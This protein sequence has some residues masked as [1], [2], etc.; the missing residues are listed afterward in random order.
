MIGKQVYL[1]FLFLISLQ[2]YG[3]TTD[4][5][6]S[7][8]AQNLNGTAISQVDIYEDFQ[9]LVTVLNSGNSVE[10]TTLSI[11]FDADLSINS[12]NS[13][14]N[15]S[16]ASD[17][18]NISITDNILT[19]SIAN[20]PNN[21]SVEL[22]ILVTAPTSIGGITANGTVNPPD[23][24]QDTN[25]SNNQ[26]IIS[27]DVLDV[28]IDFSITHTQIQPT[29]GTAIAAWGDSVTYQFTITN[30]SAIDFPLS[31]I[32]G[33]LSLSSPYDNGQ[34]LVQFIA[35]ECI[36][37]TNGT[38]CP[39][40]TNFTGNSTSI[41][42]SSTIFLFG[43]PVEITAGGSI[44]F[45]M[46]YQYT[47]FTC[48][49]DPMPITVDSQISVAYNTSSLTTIDSNSVT[50]DLL[51]AELCQE[52]DICIETVQTNPDISEVIDYEQ[53]ITFETTI[54]NNGPS[55]AP[56]RFFFQNL[57]TLT[58][59][60]SA[61][62]CLATTGAVSC[63]DFSLSNNGQI[64]VS[65]DFILEPNTTITIETVLSY[66]EPECG[67]NHNEVVA[68]IRSATNILDNQIIDTNPDNNYFTN[69]VVLP[70][71]EPC[72]A[73]DLQVS[74]TQTNPELPIGISED[75]TAP[76][77]LVTYDVTVTNVG[78][79]DAIIILDDFMSLPNDSNASLSAVLL[80]VECIE[81]TGTATCFNIQ[82]ANIGVPV[83]GIIENG[84][85]DIFWQ[86]T[87]EDNWELPANSSVS[88]NLTI[89]WTPECSTDPMIGLNAVEVSYA[90]D[91][92][93]STPQNNTASLRTYFAPCIDLVVQTYPEFSQVNTNQTFNWIVDISNSSTSSDAIDVLFENT[94]N[95]V[96][97]IVGNPICTVTSGS[98]TCMTN[99]NSTDN[100]ITGT[101][102]SMAAGS[103]V[104]ISIPVMAPSFGGAFNN[105]A[106]A[107]PD[108]ANNEEL[109][110][111]SNI[112]INSIQIIA[113][114][115]QKSFTPNIIVEGEESE[116]LFTVYNL[117]SNPNQTNISFLDNLPSGIL[118]SGTLSWIEANGCT[119]T[120]IGTIDD[121]FVGLENLVFPEGVAS[122]SFSVMVTSNTPGIYLNNFQNFSNNNNI[123]TSQTSATLEVIIDTSN[124]DIEI[125]KTVSPSEAVMG[126]DVDFTITATNLGTT[127][128][129]L[130]EVIDNLPQ[131]YQFF[132][133]Q[134]SF[135]VF[136]E[137]TF[138]WNIPNLNPNAFETL[139][140][141]ARVIASSNLTNVALL[142]SVNEVDRDLSNNEDSA[143]VE[144]SNCLMIPEGIS[145]NNDG[146]NDVL[147]IPCI[148]DYAENTL[149]I[150]NRYGTQIYEAQNY[151]NTWDGKANMGFPKSSELL[152]V[153]TYFYILSINSFNDP[154]VGYIY[155]NY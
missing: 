19:A 25:T 128:A 101:I 35:L 55:A 97:T 43:N 105:I 64:W 20:M 65:T 18:S 13:Q 147:F 154:F 15:T 24:I 33:L 36:A 46:T 86:I 7:V 53:D 89:D 51:L 31:Y 14:N 42:S 85:P 10:N 62:N 88:F 60:I 95:P 112:S 87:A 16:G 73:Y 107:I 96:F 75:I 119:A 136:D 152:P 69:S 84:E 41:Q 44:T 146:K 148:E 137:T 40:L 127:T 58:W 124:V 120:F 11:N 135:G 48:S 125:T 145:P 109:T 66:F 74:K 26:A 81:T 151:L 102:P 118:L 77:G 149:K 103:S 126:Q 28:P 91:L 138:I 12:Y 131:G 100:F 83:D 80:N 47:N 45:E 27:I 143:T 63:N 8:E 130:I 9:Y 111:D 39:D 153:G 72:D 6:I 22:L 4:L 150:Y 134:T 30:T 139:T 38:I 133:A 82:N 32:E 78:D 155:L 93:D 116:L 52:T 99:F 59:D 108:A 104:R 90:N 140:I 76:W 106:E 123:D 98:A 113:P 56:M 122:C 17:I 61:I 67:V 132:S 94:V 142:N 114:T 1:L 34:P 49:P 50:T 117:A 92:I 23:N 144:I 3:Q 2:I 57:S 115:L 70:A 68:Q 110:P 37:T 71:V 79:E 129:T 29:E 5:S 121:A 21:S 54:C 141:T